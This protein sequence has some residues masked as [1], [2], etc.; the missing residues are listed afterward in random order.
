M[1]FNALA[2]AFPKYASPILAAAVVLP[3]I[4]RGLTAV[5]N[6]GGLVGIWRSIMFGS[7]TI[8]NSDDPGTTFRKKEADA[9]P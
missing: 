9:K 5:R 2:Q 1:D 8:H 6:G 3:M 7:T 4:G